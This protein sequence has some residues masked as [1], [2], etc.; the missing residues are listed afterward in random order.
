MNLDQIHERT[1]DVQMVGDV[2]DHLTVDPR[3][4]G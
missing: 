3:A 4:Y 1:V 2:S